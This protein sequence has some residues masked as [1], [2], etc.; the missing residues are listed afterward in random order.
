M[1]VTT[2]IFKT[3][4]QVDPSEWDRLVEGRP[5]ADR[6]WLQVTEA[7]LLDHQPRYVLLRQ[8]GRLEAGAVCSIQR[9]FHSRVLQAALGW[10]PRHFPSLRCDMPIYNGTGLFFADPGQFDKLFPELLDGLQTLFRQERILFYSFDHLLP[11]D[12]A[13]A[14]LQARGHHRIDHMLDAR[15]EIHWT[16]F[17][18]YLKSLPQEEYEK[19]VQIRAGLA[20][21]GITIEAVDP[22]A[23]DPAV[24][25]RLWSGQA[26]REREPHMYDSDL[27]PKVFSLMGKDLKLIVARQEGRIVGC[28]FMLHNCNDWFVKWHGL[29]L[30]ATANTGTH[31]GMLAECIHQAILAGGR[32]IRLGLIE[33]RT[34]KLLGATAERRIGATAVRSRP[35]HWLA[36]RFLGMT[37]NRYRLPEES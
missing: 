15:L 4:D 14:F 25:D 13:W 16:S 21:Q 35:L 27:F 17:E 5:F 19:H 20:S 6:H 29:D 23:E 31:Q 33:D 18:D 32:Q 36:G 26:R 11:A 24:L 10:L 1:P 28:V 30:A 2:E 12:P 9:R 37:V 8:D 34:I 7:L 22:L 3:I